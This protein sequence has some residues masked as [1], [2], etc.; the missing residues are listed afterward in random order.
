[1]A[2]EVQGVTDLMLAFTNGSSQSE[3]MAFGWN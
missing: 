1:M 2:Q 3:S